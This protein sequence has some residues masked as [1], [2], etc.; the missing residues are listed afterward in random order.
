MH[1]LL[2][3]LSYL[4]FSFLIL[5]F[6]LYFCFRHFFSSSSF[7]SHLVFCYSIWI[8]LG[9][10]L[11][12]YHCHICHPHHQLGC[13]QVLCHSMRIFVGF[14]LLPVLSSSS[15][16]VSSSVV[17]VV[18]GGVDV[19]DPVLIVDFYHVTV[20]VSIHSF[21]SLNMLLLLPL[22]H[23]V[24]WILFILVFGGFKLSCLISLLDFNIS[25]L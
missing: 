1:F 6:L 14:W 12:Q 19:L 17:F 21:P 3:L 10:V 2:H 23:V 13:T 5:I 7:I 8:V 16:C 4:L 9:L 22:L 18:G 25:S 20:V 24:D 15:L 11:L